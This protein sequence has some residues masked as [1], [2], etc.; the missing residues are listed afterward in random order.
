M[1][2]TALQKILE[3][4]GPKGKQSC[5]QLPE[6]CESQEAQARPCCFSLVPK[7]FTL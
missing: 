3:A 5:S 6:E 1:D 2:Q 4:S 7:E